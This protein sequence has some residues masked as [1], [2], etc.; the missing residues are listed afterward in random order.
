MLRIL[1]ADDHPVVRR[2]L[3]QTLVEM[4]DAITVDEATDG[5]EALNK[6]RAGNY[7]IIILDIAMPGENGI[8][9]LERIKVEK[10]NLPVLVLSMYPEEQFAVRALKTGASGYLTKGS[11]PDELVSAIQKVLS[12]GKYVSSSLAEQLASLLQQAELLPHESLSNR[13]FQVMRLIASGKTATEITK[14]LFLSIKTVSTYRSRILKKMGMKN[15]VELA[16]Y[17]EKHNLAT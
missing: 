9:V 14:E 13:E 16:R 12:G 10:P 7:D 17:A 11:T 5:I 8:E 3:K 1:I 2:G 6:A 15:N 4:P